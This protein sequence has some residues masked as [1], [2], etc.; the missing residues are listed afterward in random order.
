M[1]AVAALFYHRSLRQRFI[2][3]CI[4]ETPFSW[5]QA[6][7]ER[8]ITKP[9]SW[10]WGTLAKILPQILAKKQ[11]LKLCWN[12]NRFGN[13]QHCGGDGAA[14]AGVNGDSRPGF[15]PGEDSDFHLEVL[16]EAVSSEKWWLYTVMLSKLNN[17]VQSLSVWA[18]NC[19]CHGW[20]HMNHTSLPHENVEVNTDMDAAQLSP[21]D[22]LEATRKL[23]G[24]NCGDSDGKGFI[25]CPLAGQRAVELANGT[26]WK[27][28]DDND[29]RKKFLEEILSEI[30][31]L[32]QKHCTTH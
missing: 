28:L 15:H 21:Q 26:F 14:N 30:F 17:F 11:V 13:P 19:P 23:L 18:E 5:L 16:S 20:L 31:A 32:M 9:A 1:K 7:A 29:T 27:M 3:T 2:A 8:P 6:A 22:Y 25:S 4:L 10:R 24:F 12:P